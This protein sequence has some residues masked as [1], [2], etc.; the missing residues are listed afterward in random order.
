MPNE[1]ETASR[2][3][4]KAAL[5]RNHAAATRLA[6]ARD[7]VNWVWNDAEAD[8]S[9]EAPLREIARCLSVVEKK[10]RDSAS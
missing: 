4:K 1:T 8:P 9:L 6:V 10:L 5:L 3:E 7:L 2:G